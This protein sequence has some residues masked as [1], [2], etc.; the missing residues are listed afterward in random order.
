[1]RAVLTYH[2]IDD[3]GSSISVRPDAF[4]RHVRWLVSGRV[5]VMAL[6]DLARG[7]SDAPAVAL[8]FDDGFENFATHAAPLLTAHGLPATVFVVTDRVGQTND[9]N[10]T[11][12]GVPILPLLNWPALERLAAAGIAVGAHTRTHRDL[13][14]LDAA[15][16]ED[17]IAGSAEC[18]RR[19]MGVAPQAFAY[20]YGRVSE[21]VSA[22]V[23]ANFAWGCTTE[24]RP[25]D[26]AE[27][28]ERLPRLDMYYYRSGGRLDAW[29][30][31]SF[32]RHLRM[33]Q[34]RRRLRSLLS[35]AWSRRR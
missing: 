24:H 34:Q 31:S 5:Q 6:D 33:T 15:A 21:A 35:L 11:A 22:A 1:M 7:Q 13:T 29:D 26:T 14:A 10:G 19:R 9:W 18:L 2:S 17:E 16:M 12:A 28:R 4:E 30:T 20:P 32:R 8:T 23:A 3:S 27:R 25:F